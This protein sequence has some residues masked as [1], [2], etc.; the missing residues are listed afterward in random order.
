MQQ[1][2]NESAGV[3]AEAACRRRKSGRKMCAWQSE[4]VCA[5][6][7]VCQHEDI[8]HHSLHMADQEQIMAVASYMSRFHHRHLPAIRR[9]HVDVEPGR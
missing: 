3:S 5:G 2:L 8:A 6:R 9:S 1:M 4:S 7:A